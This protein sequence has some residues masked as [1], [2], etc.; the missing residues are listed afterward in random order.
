MQIKLKIKNIWI[1]KNLYKRYY[2]K[3]ILVDSI[4]YYKEYNTSN[5]IVKFGGSN[6]PEVYKT[7]LVFD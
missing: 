1:L 2:K 6:S 4:T 5:Y 7:W 3:D